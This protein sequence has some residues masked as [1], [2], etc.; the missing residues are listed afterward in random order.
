MS[1][2][3]FLYFGFLATVFVAIGL[4]LW[5]GG[6]PERGGAGVLL[7]MLAISW[8]AG[9]FV[10]TVGLSE[11]AM[12]AISVS[13]DVAGLGGFGLIATRARRVWPLVCTAMQLLS[14]LTHV[15][16]FLGMVDRPIVLNFMNHTPTFTATVSLIVGTLLHVRRSQRFGP[17]RDWQDFRNLP[18]V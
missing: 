10:Q 12:R 9:A 11:E 16:Y 5:K 2:L 14:V 18:S 15:V 6:E 17:E 7:V 3:Q 1:V 8:F 13:E 4:S